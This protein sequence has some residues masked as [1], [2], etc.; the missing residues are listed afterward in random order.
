M[1]YSLVESGRCRNGRLGA[2][3]S[4]AKIYFRLSCLRTETKSQREHKALTVRPRS[5]TV[6][7]IKLINLYFHLI[8]SIDM[9]EKHLSRGEVESYFT[10]RLWGFDRKLRLMVVGE[11]FLSAWFPGHFNIIKSQAPAKKGRSNFRTE[12]NS[13]A[14]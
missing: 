8:I 5:L 6:G 11:K 9:A 14:T 13:L 10:L 1:I 4:S 12:T 7:E 3:N 2:R